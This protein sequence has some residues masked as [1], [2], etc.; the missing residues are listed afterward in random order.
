[1]YAPNFGIYAA[2]FVCLFYISVV[3]AAFSKDKEIG[4]RDKLWNAHSQPFGILISLDEHADMGQV[5]NQLLL[6]VLIRSPIYESV[7]LM[8]PSLK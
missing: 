2:F 7:I 4:I 8:L 6:S 1:M 3:H 5:V